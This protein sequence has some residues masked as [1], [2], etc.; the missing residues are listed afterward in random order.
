MALQQFGADKV[1]SLCQKIYQ[2]GK[3]PTGM[4]KSIFITIPQKPKA[5]DCEDFRTISLMSHVMKVL[6]KVILNRIKNK[7]NAEV[8]REQFG[9]GPHLGTREAIFYMRM[10]TERCIGAHKDVFACFIDYSKAFDKIHHIKLIESLNKINLDGKDIQL[11]SSLYWQQLAAIRTEHD[12]SEYIEI[13]RGVRQGC[14]LSP[15]LFNLCT[16]MIFRE[17]V[18]KKGVTIS[19]VNINNL[20]YADHTVLMA[21]NH[22]D[23]QELLQIVKNNRECYCLHVKIKKTKSMVFSKQKEKTPPQLNLNGDIIG[24]VQQYIYLGQQLTDDGRC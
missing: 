17:V 24:N 15:T 4:M 23:L 10:T 2:T 8:S 19:G 14:V 22:Q 3:I 6:L 18:D 13:K 9:F 7:V 20:R 11:I 12:V 5:V 16:E 1:A 21:N